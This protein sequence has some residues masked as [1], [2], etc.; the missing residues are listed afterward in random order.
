M[1]YINTFQMYFV[2]K[3][4]GIRVVTNGNTLVTKSIKMK[5]LEGSLVF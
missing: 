3:K 1:L 4:S 2:T 5:V